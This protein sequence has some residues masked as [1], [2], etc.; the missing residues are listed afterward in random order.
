MSRTS[1]RDHRR[2]DLTQLRSL[3]ATAGRSLHGRLRTV[4][5]VLRSATTVFN[6][7]APIVAAPLGVRSRCLHAGAVQNWD[8][9]DGLH[10]FGFPPSGP[11]IQI[12][13]SDTEKFIDF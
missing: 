13:S 9:A 10:L 6:G 2:L 8:F 5:E 3:P 7:D 1:P 11:A 12:L 4:N